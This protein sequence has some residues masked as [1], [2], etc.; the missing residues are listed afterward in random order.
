MT[1][2]IWEVLQNIFLPWNFVSHTKRIKSPEKSYSK[3]MFIF[4]LHPELTIISTN[5]KEKQEA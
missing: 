2:Y 1:K 4:I 5:K 3:E